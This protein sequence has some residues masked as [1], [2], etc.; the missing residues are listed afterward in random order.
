MKLLNAIKR[1]LHAAKEKSLQQNEQLTQQIVQCGLRQTHHD[2][3][4]TALG[5]EKSKSAKLMDLKAHA[6]KF[7]KKVL[8]QTRTCLLLPENENNFQLMS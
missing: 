4:V 6:A 2:I 5:K 8:E 1:A 3:I 7:R